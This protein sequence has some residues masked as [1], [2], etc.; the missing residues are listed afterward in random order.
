MIKL[1]IG[2]VAVVLGLAC[3]TS[4]CKRE[5]GP[6]TSL[7]YAD[8]CSDAQMGKRISTEGYLEALSSTTC[9]KVGCGINFNDNPNTPGTD[10]HRTMILVVP[11][12]TDPNEMAEL[13]TPFRDA[14]V[15]FHTKKGDVSVGQK[16]RV[17]G[18]ITSVVHNK[19][20]DPKTK[21]MVDRANCEVNDPI[22]EQ[23]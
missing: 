6:S 10:V 2:V 5:P 15:K 1:R 21:E 7:P 20:A 16:V 3:A 9:K 13:P 11:V 14:D 19:V 18:L 8:A 22:I 4:A 17:S 23:L 12:G